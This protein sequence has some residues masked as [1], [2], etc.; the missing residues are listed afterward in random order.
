LFHFFCFNFCFFD[1]ALV[2][3][4]LM[5]DKFIFLIFHFPVFAKTI[6]RNGLL[7]IAAQQLTKYY[8]SLVMYI[9]EMI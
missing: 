8:Y 9:L 5:F 2:C 3:Y 6:F 4:F 7:V 1:F